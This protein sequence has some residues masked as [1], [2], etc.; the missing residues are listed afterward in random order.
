LSGLK[1]NRKDKSDHV[2]EGRAGSTRDR[3]DANLQKKNHLF[4]KGRP[5]ER[6]DTAGGSDAVEGIRSQ[7]S[8]KKRKE[9]RKPA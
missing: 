3:K 4:R 5:A 6:Q 7:R 9:K 1:K 2:E 8:P